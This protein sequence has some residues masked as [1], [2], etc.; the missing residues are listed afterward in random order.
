M[1]DN[2]IVDYYYCNPRC[3]PAAIRHSKRP[4]SPESTRTRIRNQYLSRSLRK[5][6]GGIPG[7]SRANTGNY[8]SIVLPCYYSPQL[9]LSLERHLALPRALPVC[10]CRCRS[11]VCGG[12]DL[13]D[14]GAPDTFAAELSAFR[15]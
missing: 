7:V 2:V 11:R 4:D 5:K 13:V 14:A 8:R 15:D 1:R 6:L 3:K 12:R 10:G 9:R